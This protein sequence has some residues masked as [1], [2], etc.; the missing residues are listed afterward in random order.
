M[1]P[2]AAGFAYQDVTAG[3][4][5][6]CMCAKGLLESESH[7]LRRAGAGCVSSLSHRSLAKAAHDTHRPGVV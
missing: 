2:R 6:A 1:D 7:L 3:S 4:P 5:D